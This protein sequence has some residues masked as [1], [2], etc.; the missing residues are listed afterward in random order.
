MSHPIFEVRNEVSN[1]KLNQ[2]F[3]FD[4]KFIYDGNT[5][6]FLDYQKESKL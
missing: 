2:D 6:N 5:R 4:K 1:Q 3:Y